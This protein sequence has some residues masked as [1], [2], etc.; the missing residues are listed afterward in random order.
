MSLE[1]EKV[2]EMLIDSYELKEKYIAERK[3]TRKIKNINNIC[4]LF[5]I[6][7]IEEGVPYS[8]IENE[9]GGIIQLV[10]EGN[11]YDCN[12]DDIMELLGE[13]YENIIGKSYKELTGK[14]FETK[15]D[16]LFGNNIN[17]SKY[18]TP[19]IIQ[20]SQPEEKK[21]EPPKV[22][23]IPPKVYLNE[24][25]EAAQLYNEN[26]KHKH[27]IVKRLITLIIFV[28]I[29]LACIFV[30]SINNGIKNIGNKISTSIKSW[31]NKE[32][33]TEEETSKASTETKTP[34][35]KSV[36]LNNTKNK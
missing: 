13:N 19:I 14:D 24:E 9:K 12:N 29:I 7:L 31:A 22:D 6:F 15:K 18:G 17:A 27:K 21:Q 32:K 2:A 1:I 33:A 8:F 35:E 25:D 5:T 4:T 3:P 10:I 20:T 36:P 26:K 28:A 11:K 16:D 30:P 23:Y 34:I